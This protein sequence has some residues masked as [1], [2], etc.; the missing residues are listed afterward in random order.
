MKLF[1]RWL[2]N[3]FG[4]LFAAYIVKGIYVED[5]VTAIVAAAVLGIMNLLIRPILLILTLPL[6]IL[7]L[8]LFT[9]FLN[10]FIFYFIG[11][12][13]KGMAVANFWSAFIGALIVSIVNAVAHFFLTV[14]HLERRE[15]GP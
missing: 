12:L 3:T 9:L 15:P 11:N 5:V 4:I 8:G 2:I 13:V 10:G 7:T 1:I 14:D 6:N